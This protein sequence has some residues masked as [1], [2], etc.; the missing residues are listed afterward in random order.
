MPLAL[1]LKEAQL[2]L[3]T[4]RGVLRAD[5]ALALGDAAELLRWSQD[6]ARRIRA[7]A[8]QQAQ[9]MAEQ[10]RHETERR[11]SDAVAQAVAEV[12]VKAATLLAELEPVVAQTVVQVL[13][14]LAAGLDRQ[15]LLAQ[16]L[17]EVRRVVDGRALAVLKVAPAD[18][19]H[20]NQAVTQMIDEAQL[21]ASFEL[22]PDPALAPGHCVLQSA[23][24]LYRFGLEH[25][26]Q[27]LRGALGLPAQVAEAADHA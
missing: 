17:A 16:A 18:L 26:L 4:E 27:A 25:Q 3:A 11:T 12:H 2:L 14:R 7:Q 10:A 23:A 24:G 15:A 8:E 6:E 1:V 19:P 20:A 21:P 9:V 5:E 13:V 22:R